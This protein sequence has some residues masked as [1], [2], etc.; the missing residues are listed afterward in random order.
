MR[1]DGDRQSAGSL[2]R[3]RL[4]SLRRRLSPRRASLEA[5]VGRV[6]LRLRGTVRAPRTSSARRSSAAS[7]FW[8]WLRRP[9]WTPPGRCPPRRGARRVSMS[10]APGRRRRVPAKRRRSRAA[11]CAWTR[12]S[13]AGPRRRPRGSPGTAARDGN[14]RDPFTRSTPS[15]PSVTPCVTSRP[16]MTMAECQRAHVR[17]ALALCESPPLATPRPAHLQRA[18]SL[19][20]P[21]AAR[22]LG[23]RG[24]CQHRRGHL[25]GRRARLAGRQ[26][27]HRQAARRLAE[28][29]G[30]ARRDRVLGGV[31]RVLAA[32]PSAPPSSTC[33]RSS[34]C[35]S[36]RRSCTSRT[37]SSSTVRG[38]VHP[39][40]R[41]RVAAPAR[42]RRPARRGARQRAVRRRRRFFGSVR[43][44]AR[45]RPSGSSSP[46]S[47][48]SRSAFA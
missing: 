34:T 20:R 29:R 5:R 42:R 25:H 11:R 41:H 44:L 36:S 32:A 26:Y 35:C 40:H 15:L 17:G 13:R 37:R 27:R 45:R 14:R 39:R 4:V 22:A 46:S 9:R 7:R 8:A 3:W 47:P 28:L 43:L 18:C 10:R 12:C 6:A 31:Q 30:H 2:R 33:S 21:R 38:A 16:M 1:R 24:A 23:L 19:P 48:S